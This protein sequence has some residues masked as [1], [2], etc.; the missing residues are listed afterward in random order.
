MKRAEVSILLAGV[1]LALIQFSGCAQKPPTFN[2]VQILAPKG[3][4]TIAQSAE[5]KRGK[6]ICLAANI[7]SARHGGRSP[8]LAV[9][10]SITF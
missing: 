7:P 2:D 3:A 8:C 10:V 9:L 4:Q 6:S 1:L 5:R